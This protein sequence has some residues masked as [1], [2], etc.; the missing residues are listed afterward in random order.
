MPESFPDV[1]VSAKKGESFDLPGR[2]GYQ[3]VS[4]TTG[5]VTG[6]RFPARIRFRPIA[7]KGFR[8]NELSHKSG[9]ARGMLHISRCV[10]ECKARGWTDVTPQEVFKFLTEHP[11]YG[12]DFVAVHDGTQVDVDRSGQLDEWVVPQP[13]MGKHAIYCTLC[14]KTMAQPQHYVGHKNSK[15]HKANL[16]RHLAEIGGLD[17]VEASEPPVEK[18]VPDPV[19]VSPSPV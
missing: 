17:T 3:H 18:N 1:F 11:R 13:A 7:G 10:E 6:A 15:I 2:L 8:T 5:N 14:D 9:I 16:E 19:Q 12:R 4:P